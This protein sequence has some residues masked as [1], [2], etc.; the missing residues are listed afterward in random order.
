M[1]LPSGRGE[2]VGDEE[3]LQRAII[4]KGQ[5]VKTK[6]RVKP[7]L[8]SPPPSL[9]LSVTRIDGLN[10]VA[11]RDLADDVARQR[12]KN[13]SLGYGKLYA[14]TP[15]KHGLDVIPDE[16]PLHHANL[17]GWPADN[18]PDEQRRRQLQVA[19][20]LVEEVELILWD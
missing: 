8:L 13:E 14:F 5:F 6:G 20:S 11:I 7:N 9:Q 16:P 12:G 18:D 4:S 10:D 3:C 2:V 19:K 17:V 15:R 1:E